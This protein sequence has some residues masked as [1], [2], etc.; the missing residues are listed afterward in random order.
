M[1]EAWN[2]KRLEYLSVFVCE[3]LGLQ[4][5]DG[6]VEFERPLALG[7]IVDLQLLQLSLHLPQLLRQIL[8]MQRLLLQVLLNRKQTHSSEFCFII[9]SYMSP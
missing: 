3:Y 6:A 1:V 9:H 2:Q 7:S 5:V 8:S 4:S